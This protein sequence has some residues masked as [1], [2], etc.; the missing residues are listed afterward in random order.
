[1]VSDKVTT[2][3]DLKIKLAFEMTKEKHQKNYKDALE[4]GMLHYIAD[5]DPILACELRIQK[6]ETLLQDEQQNLANLKLL[7][8]IQKSEPKKQHKSFD[9][10]LERLRLDKFESKKST[11]T[12]QLKN[13]SLDWTKTSKVFM[14]NTPGEAREWIMPKLQEAELLE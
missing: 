10:G 14:F 7:S 9:P 8:Q 11:L 2:N 6:Y 3:A 12:L 5:V 4:T 13:G 1:M